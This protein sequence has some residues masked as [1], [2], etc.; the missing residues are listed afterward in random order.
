MHIKIVIEVYDSGE[1]V[2]VDEDNVSFATADLGLHTGPSELEE[3]TDA[4]RLKIYD[5]AAKLRGA[6]ARS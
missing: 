6:K 4:V 5:L 1:V 2:A 3:L